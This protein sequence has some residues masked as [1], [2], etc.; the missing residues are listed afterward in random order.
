MNAIRFDACSAAA[1]SSSLMSSGAPG[2]A[3]VSAPS[4]GARG[5]VPTQTIAAS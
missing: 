5:R 3:R 4:N 1:A 2:P